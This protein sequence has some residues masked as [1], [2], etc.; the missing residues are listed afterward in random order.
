MVEHSNTLGSKLLILCRGLVVLAVGLAIGCH[1]AVHVR[2]QDASGASATTYASYE[3]IR[4]PVGR[5]GDV[6]AIIEEALHGGMLAK[7][8][9]PASSTAPDLLVSYKVLLSEDIRALDE[10]QGPPNDGLNGDVM[11]RSAQPVWDFVAN[12]GLSG[13]QLGSG[14]G[15]W[16]A[17]GPAPVFDAIPTIDVS[18]LSKPSK[19]K[20]LI[21]MLQDPTSLRV[22]WL[23]WSTTDV[24]PRTFAATTRTAIGEIV[25]RLPSA[26]SALALN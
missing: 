11:D 19:S 2:H 18:Y 16:P 1:S 5:S 6:D 17:P 8:Y 13:P 9:E 25:E 24:S 10:S 20:T 14:S 23:G 22:V 15:S 7:G 12:D 3:V 26:R 21:V 4:H